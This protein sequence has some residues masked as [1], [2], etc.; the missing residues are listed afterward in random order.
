M[1][2]SDI[3][4]DSARR[5]IKKE[6]KYIGDV[7]VLGA[8]TWAIRNVLEQ[9]IKDNYS[10]IITESNSMIA[11]QAIKEKSIPSKDIAT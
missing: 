10:K 6:E 1:A 5:I 4:R 2:I 3:C 8:E 9:A 7:P 11:L